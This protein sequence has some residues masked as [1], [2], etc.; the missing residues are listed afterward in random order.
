VG[1]PGW[2]LSPAGLSPAGLALAFD[3]YIILCSLRAMGGV[4]LMARDRFRIVT[5]IGLVLWALTIG[6]A[7]AQTPAPIDLTGTSLEDL[8]N[9]QVTSVSK[10]EQTLSKAAS[11]V[12]VIT[13][14]DIRHSGAT[15]VPDL[16][17]MVP[18][19]DVA[20]INANTWAISIRGFNSR[21]A[22]KVLVLVDGRTVFTPLFS[23][24]Y[25][26]QQTMPLENIERIEVIRGP[27]GTVWGANAMNGV[28]NIIS[29]SAKDTHGVLISAEAGSQDRAQG[30][31]QYGGSA[32]ADGSFRVFGRYTINE[33]S[34]SIPLSPATDDAHNSQMGFRSDWILSSR[35]TLTAQGDLLGE[36][37]S[38]TDITLFL[39]QPLAYHTVNA[40]VRVAAGN[41][42]G[43]WNHVFAN[44][45]ET[46]LQI[47]YDSFR[48]FEMGLE[49]QN[50]G[51]AD[52]QYH[53]KLGDRNDIVTG[54]GYRLTDERFRDGYEAVIGTGHHQEGLFS[55]FVQDELRL[56]KL[57][58]LTMGV[59]LEHNAY[60]G[61][62]FEPTVQFAWSP[63]SH[64]TVWASVSRALQQPSWFYAQGVVD[65]ALV[66]VPGAG[67][68]V[69]QLDGD[70]EGKAPAV[71]SYELGYRTE[72]SKRLTLDTTVF[73]SDYYRLQTIEPQAAL[74]ATSPAPPHL[75]LPSVFGNLAGGST[76]GTE[77][78]A[79]WDV[80]KWWRISPG[81]S[82][83]QTNLSLNHG[84]TDA[85]IAFTSADSPKRQAQ[86][87]SSVKLPH[88]VEWDTSVYFVGALATV[89]AYTRVDTR[90][91]WHIGEFVDMGIT[92]QNLLTPRHVEFLDSLQITPMETARAIVARVTWHF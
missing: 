41:L 37:E 73:L 82:F 90:V 6:P 39:N 81:F 5:A 87:R 9:I 83:L 14:D 10:K 3:A 30:L 71:V 70:P 16:L 21:Y 77:I 7:A 64:Q 26:D 17:R 59:K 32:G 55:T 84:V 74:V 23:G 18:G 92:G 61:F 79:H 48:R 63:T 12:Y 33:D 34:P 65:E 31:A 68:A 38:Q 1:W 46:T 91:G 8:M 25:W 54:T 40:Q 43:R 42:L 62:E 86:L 69:F 47:Y 20:R 15:N 53:L 28:I 45:S 80:S 35:D 67:T 13:E 88:R 36:S 89:A 2:W 57:V 27:G 58:S 22:G 11:S 75:V 29:K 19:V 85:T 51:D 56:T 24:V 4:K 49:N 60:T 76:Y 52:F 72:L 78:S 44:G 66:Q 50:T